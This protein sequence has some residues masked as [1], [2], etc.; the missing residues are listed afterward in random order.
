MKGGDNVLKKYEINQKTILN[1][2]PKNINNLEEKMKQWKT[3]F[4]NK[5]QNYYFVMLNDKNYMIHSGE[6][7]VFNSL[8]NKKT[9][10]AKIFI[11]KEKFMN[12]TIAH[13]TKGDVMI[14]ENKQSFNNPTSYY[15]E[16]QC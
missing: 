2:L 13:Y 12:Y 4:L 3:N 5:Y 14:D 16:N 7:N 1:F 10:K 8:K 11:N 15:C 9:K 6:L